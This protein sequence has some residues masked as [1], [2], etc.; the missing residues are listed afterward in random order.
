M[1]FVVVNIA[2]LAMRSTNTSQRIFLPLTVCMVW[3][4]EGVK[5]EMRGW[6]LNEQNW[7]EFLVTFIF[8]QDPSCFSWRNDTW[9]RYERFVRTGTLFGK[10][11]CRILRWRWWWRGII[12]D[13]MNRC[14]FRIR[15]RPLWTKIR[16]V[17]WEKAIDMLNRKENEGKKKRL[18]T[19]IHWNNK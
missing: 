14:Y 13:R 7:N 10:L 9:R 12:D 16:H 15:W 3:R 19:W 2:I 17:A 6:N 8:G 18:I 4:G 5:R 1:T 11:N